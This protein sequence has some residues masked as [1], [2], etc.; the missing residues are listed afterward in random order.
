MQVQEVQRQRIYTDSS[1]FTQTAAD[2]G[3]PRSAERLFCFEFC[4]VPYTARP[5]SLPPR[6]AMAMLKGLAQSPMA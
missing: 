1:G 3:N 4:P 2:R 5:A 6:M